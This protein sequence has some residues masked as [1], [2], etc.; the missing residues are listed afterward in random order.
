[1]KEENF[2]MFMD[3]KCDIPESFVSKMNKKGLDPKKEFLAILE[4]HNRILNGPKY[5]EKV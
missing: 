3:V 2:I 4:Q 1:M 5:Y